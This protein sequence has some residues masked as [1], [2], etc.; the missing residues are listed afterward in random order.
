MNFTKYLFL[1]LLSIGFHAFAQDLDV[2]KVK[3]N[4]NF[5]L[6]D[7]PKDM[8]FQEFELLSTNLRMQDMVIA[9]V[10]PGHVH[11]KIKEKKAGYY[12]LGTRSLG[13]A[14][15]AYLSIKEESLLNML[16]LPG[17]NYLYNI[18][19]GDKIVA[20]TSVV[21]IVGSYLYDWIHGKYILDKKQNKIR[22][23]YAKKRTQIGLSSIRINHKDY[24]ALAL[25]YSF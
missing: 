4:S 6:P 10:L 21:L 7:I 20:Y 23:K 24:P 25:T 22:Y 1:L 15:W 3:K 18:S 16:F 13:Y 17:Y 11:F 9:A 5:E 19:T 2:Y 14:G 12:L 8:T